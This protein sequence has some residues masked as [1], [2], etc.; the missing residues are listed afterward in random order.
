M[1]GDKIYLVGFMA[2]GKSTVAR[3]LAARLG[4]RF[5]DIDE[6]IERRERLTIADIFARHGEAY[7][8]GSNGKSSGCFNRSATSWSRPGAARSRTPT[9][10]P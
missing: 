3:M 1:T 4:W 10:G 7:F 8:R 6:L 9:I 5:E 2:S